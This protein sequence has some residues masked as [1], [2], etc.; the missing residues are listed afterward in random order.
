MLHDRS[1][2]RGLTLRPR[3][4]LAAT[5]LLIA[6]LAGSGAAALV[7][8]F[9]E[10]AQAQSAASRIDQ[11]TAATMP[12]AAERPNGDVPPAR[13]LTPATDVMDTGSVGGERV[14]PKDHLPVSTRSAR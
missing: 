5:A 12:E 4:G 13:A 2:R 10:L 8:D 6:G 11:P 3:A 1:V 9:V 7:G 14:N